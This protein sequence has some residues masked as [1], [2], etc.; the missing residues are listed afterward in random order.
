M[1]FRN[2]A[3]QL[4]GSQQN[5]NIRLQERHAD[6]QTQEHNGDADW[7]QRKENPGNHVAGKHIG[8]KTDGERKHA[9]QVADEFDGN[10]QRR[11]GWNG[12]GKVLQVTDPGVLE[13]LH[14][15]IHEGANRA[16]QGN[17]GHGCWR[18]QAWNHSNQVAKQNEEAKRGQ[19][20]CV[21]LTVVT[22]DLVALA[23]DESFNALKG[24]LQRAGTVHRKP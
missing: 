21:T 10:H 12:S 9:G 16:T 13:S 18:L 7:Y 20:R 5:E 1:L 17:D 8:G 2:R 22:D 15:V 24:V 14:L 6:V 3:L 11:Q 19:K 4:D 23:L